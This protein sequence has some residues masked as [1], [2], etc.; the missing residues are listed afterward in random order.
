M[1]STQDNK[2]VNNHY[3]DHVIQV[4]ESQDIEASEDIIA[5]NGMKLLAKGAKIDARVK[6]RLVSHKLRKP[7]EECVRVTDGVTAEQVS[8]IAESLLDKHSMLRALYANSKHKDVGALLKGYSS[9]MTM[10]SMLTVYAKH[11]EGKLE[12]AVGVSLLTMGMAKKLTGYDDE[13][14]RV[15]LM[16][17]LFHDIGEL[18]I[19]PALFARGIRLTPEQWRHIAVHP[20]IGHRVIQ[21]M[22]GLGKAV[23]QVVLLHHE[24]LD[25]YGYPNGLRADKI[26]LDGQ[27][28]AV[29]ELLS[30]LMEAGRTPLT[31][32]DVA[33]KL[34]PGE[35]SRG[36]IDLVATARKTCEDE[37]AVQPPPLTDNLA[38]VR[39]I[40]GITQRLDRAKAELAPDFGQASDAFKALMQ[41]AT[42]RLHAILR[43]FSSTGMDTHDPEEL[44][45]RLSA[46]NDPVVAL[47]FT[48]VIKEIVWRL[49]ELE[50]ELTQ[51]VQILAPKEAALLH[52]LFEK[53]K[54]L[55]EVEEAQPVAAA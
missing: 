15:M 5:G 32:A 39:K 3:L 14:A 19:D 43:A 4:A 30:G 53:T 28:L 38:R 16:A 36:I 18:Y 25:G 22:Q 41:Q 6:D 11:R 9:S 37:A 34:I 27:I 1:D 52:R 42:Q 35:F 48:L 29:A 33:L 23:A 31:H 44:L 49:R 26:L 50:R 2:Q 8:G 17:G 47:E 12:H 7:L 45:S 20:I 40:A 51:R 21:E 54:P 10:Q 13:Q 46:Q 55:R 24:R